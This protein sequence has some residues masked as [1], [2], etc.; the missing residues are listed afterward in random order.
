MLHHVDPGLA[1]ELHEPDVPKPYSVTGLYFRSKGRMGD[2]YILDPAYPCIFKIRFLNDRHAQKALQYFQAKS[3]I[4]IADTTFRVASIGIRSETYRDLIERATPNVDAFRLVFKSPTYLAVRGA[5]FHHL[6]P[7]PRRL[8]L[9]L[10]KLWNYNATGEEIEDTDAYAKWLKLN[11]GVSGYALETKFVQAG[12]KELIGFMG[13]T[14]YRIKE[15]DEWGKVTCAL[16]KFAEY[17]NIGAN[18]TGGFGVTK[19]EAKVKAASL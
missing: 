10:A 7:E 1:A 3:T 8:F 15:K 19:H 17:S 5:S 11:L 14:N 16:A 12:R 18:R 6:F 9:S 2:G 4:I 13:W